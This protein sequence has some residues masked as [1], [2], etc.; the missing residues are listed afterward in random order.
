MTS[1][2]SRK[3][4][5]VVLGTALL[6]PATAAFGNQ[7]SKP[8][9][10]TRG[11]TIGAAA[12]AVLGPVGAVVGAGIGNGIQS[13]RHNQSTHHHKRHLRRR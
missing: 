3:L 5:A 9:S 2:L 8:M 1:L 13:V 6:L 7:W 12:G 10:R 4:Q 11:A